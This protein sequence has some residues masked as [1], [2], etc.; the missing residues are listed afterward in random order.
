MT[1]INFSLNLAQQLVNSVDT[2]PVDFD[3]LWKW[4][5]YGAKKDAKVMLVKN[6]EKGL[7]FSG[8][9]PKN[10]LAGRPSELIKLTT[11]CAK[12]FALLAQTENGKKV[13]QYFIEAE[14]ELKF[15]KEKERLEFAHGD[16]AAIKEI[17]EAALMYREFYGDAYVYQYVQQQMEKHQPHLAGNEP[18]KE[19]RPSLNVQAL[20]TPTQIASELNWRYKTGN[21]DARMVNRTLEYLGYQTKINGQWSATEK[22]NNLCERKPISTESKSQK[23][24]LLW[25]KRVIDILK[26]FSLA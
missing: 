17:K 16:R 11:N 22:A 1:D 25:T 20:L 5:G 9:F 2:F 12:E 7:E 3:L 15:N 23:D 14:K 4:C 21:P 8:E 10:A 26:E 19:L 24:Q 6:F 13:R 18:P